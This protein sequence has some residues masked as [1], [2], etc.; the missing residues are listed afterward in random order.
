M[1]QKFENFI[2]LAKE[3]VIARVACPI[4]LDRTLQ[5]LFLSNLKSHFENRHRI[6]SLGQFIPIPIDTYLARSLFT[7]YESS[8][9]GAG[10]GSKS[11]LPPI[12]PQGKP[13]DI[14]WFKITGG[15]I[16][17]D[18]KPLQLYP[19]QQF[20]IDS[21]KTRMIQSGVVNDILPFTAT[22]GEIT[23]NQVQQY[24]GLPEIF[25]FPNHVTNSGECSFTY[26][27]QLRKILLTSSKVRSKGLRLPTT[28]LLT[29]LSRCVGKST[30][31][32]SIS[33]ETCTNLLE[34]DGFELFNQASASK[35]IGTI[36][37]KVD[38]AVQQCGNLIL[39]LKHID[40]LTK[41]VDPQQQ[42]KE[43]L[44]LKLADLIDE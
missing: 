28:I 18:G 35:T 32:R 40:A 15:S 39:Y 19:G 34:L 4:T 17:V 24:L 31:V 20:M 26:A 33:T 13:D 3:V 6:V 8:G 9:S 25:E 22:N 12:I 1:K 27:R 44:S 37:G 36:R 38:G 42:Q 5:H 7:T 29:S 30:L 41:K 21:T 10:N 16:E 23:L 2:P 14:A 43:T 11:N